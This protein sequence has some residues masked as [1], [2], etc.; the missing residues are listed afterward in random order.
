MKKIIIILLCIL[1]RAYGQ[2]DTLA[3]RSELLS[4]GFKLF[5][6]HTDIDPAIL[7]QIPNLKKMANVKGKF[8]ATDVGNRDPT[9][10]LFFAA[11]SGNK[12]IISY[13][14]GGIGY[15]THCLFITIDT[16]KTITIKDTLR[17]FTSL[18]GLKEYAAKQAIPI[19]KDT[20]YSEY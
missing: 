3:W 1:T 7:S 17:E 16:D 12:W 9:R 14:H 13:E 10:R 2:Q 6:K 4:S 20:G 11:S 15:H 18:S 5:A 19:N 8:N